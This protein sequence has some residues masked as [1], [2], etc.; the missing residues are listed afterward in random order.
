MSKETKVDT[1]LSYSSSVL[2]KNCERKF[3]HYKVAKTAIDPDA[4]ESTEA[5]DIGKAFHQVLEDTMHDTACTNVGARAAKACEDYN[6]PHATPMIHAMLLKYLKVHKK[7]GLEAIN[8]EFG[9]YTDQ[10]IGYIDV[11]LI[12]PKT[13]EWWIADLKTAAFITATTIARL[14]KDPQLNLYAH[15]VEHLA[16]HLEGLDVEKFKGVR[17]RATTKS[18]LKQKKTETYEDYVLRMFESIRSVDAAIEVKD[19][20]IEDTWDSYEKQH[21]RALELWGG[22][23]IPKQNMS[24]CDSFFKPCQYW[25]QCHGTTYTLCQDLVKINE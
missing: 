9:L 7:S 5:F 15:F 13:G 2:L 25:S 12:D 6:V 22:E 8:C 24:Y 21:V 16:T 19:L 23:D 14:P 18:K 10:F 3:W 4:P 17:Y 20:A 1:R 11:I